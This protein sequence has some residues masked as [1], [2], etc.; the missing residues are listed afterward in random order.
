VLTSP[1]AHQ[2]WDPRSPHSRPAFP[3]SRSIV[4]L[5]SVPSVQVLTLTLPHKPNPSSN[6]VAISIVTVVLSMVQYH[7][8]PSFDR[9]FDRIGVS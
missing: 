3:P 9:D 4:P 6:Q 7:M 1:H 8:P 5:S 2:T